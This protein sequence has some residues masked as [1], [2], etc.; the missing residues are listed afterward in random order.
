MY[1]KVSK[2]LDVRL[3]SELDMYGRDEYSIRDA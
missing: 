1:K 3:K 2:L